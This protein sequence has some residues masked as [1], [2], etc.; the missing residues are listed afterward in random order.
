MVLN[1]F[2]IVK[3]LKYSVT[4][5]DILNYCIVIK[6]KKLSNILRDLPTLTH[7]HKGLNFNKEIENILIIE[8]VYSSHHMYEILFNSFSKLI[9]T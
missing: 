2:T 5:Y 1:T 9:G 8:E 4:P 3:S 7:N 6:K